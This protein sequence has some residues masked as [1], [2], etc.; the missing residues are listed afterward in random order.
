MSVV[1]SESLS[2]NVKIIFCWLQKK[3]PM[4]LRMEWSVCTI[5]FSLGQPRFLTA[6]PELRQH[7]PFPK[8]QDGQWWEK[9]WVPL[10]WNILPR[11]LVCVSHL[12][13]HIH[14]FIANAGFAPLDV[15]TVT[16]S[17]TA[18]AD[19]A[20][21]FYNDK[22]VSHV[23]MQWSASQQTRTPRCLASCCVEFCRLWN[24]AIHS[25]W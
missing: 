20:F 10:W 9:G 1:S 21:F 22:N 4:M 23:P 8:R 15:C 11:R 2:F 5:F 16:Q 7:Y 25:N 12:L 19:R 24:E 14:A 6:E 18:V 13:V 17:I 3:K